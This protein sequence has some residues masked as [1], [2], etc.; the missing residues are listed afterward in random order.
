MNYSIYQAGRTKTLPVSDIEKASRLAAEY[1]AIN[2]TSGYPDFPAP[3]ALKKAACEAVLGDRNQ[4]AKTHG[5]GALREELSRKVSFYNGMDFDP[6][7][8]VTVTCGQTEAL[9]CTM[10]AFVEAGDEVII[11]EPFYESYIPNTLMCGATPRFV[12]IGDDMS[13]DAEQLKAAF[14]EKTKAVII[15]TPNNPIGKVFT[16]GELRLIADLCV[17]HGVLAFTDE[18]YEHF[19][20]DGRKHVSLGSF[21]DMRER[22]VTTSSF[23]KTYRVTGWRV[24]YA[25]A[26]KT[27][28][29]PIRKVHD[30]VTMVAPTPLQY[31]CISALRLPESYYDEVIN[32]H[33]AKRRLL[34]DCLIRAGFKCELPQG[35]YFIMANIGDFGVEDRAFVEYLIKE[36]G[37]AAV[38]CSG[39]YH[40]ERRDMVRFTFAK[41]DETLREAC[42]RLEKM[43]K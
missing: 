6:E 29:G 12:G 36:V 17:D 21:G 1:G 14:N 38:P 3:E 5:V 35:A 41:R 34:H 4:Y 32:I 20:Y 11:F 24:G 30:C 10:L 8:E 40:T 42:A 2:L 13:L 31:A 9:A 18:V 7:T 15:N 19:V 37:V 25:L 27:L 22:T 39:F 26:D 33:D 43:I 23:S 16:K 28:S